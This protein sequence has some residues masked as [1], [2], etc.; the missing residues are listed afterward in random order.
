MSMEEALVFCIEQQAAKRQGM[1]GS[2]PW[3]T[4]TTSASSGD[5]TVTYNLT[6]THD[7]LELTRATNRAIAKGLG[8]RAV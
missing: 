4:P 8:N 1:I 6:P 2:Y 3:S 5:I 7:E